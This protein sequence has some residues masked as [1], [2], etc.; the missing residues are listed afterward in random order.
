M[1]KLKLSGLGVLAGAAMLMSGAWYY[2]KQPYWVW[3]IMAALCG[4]VIAMLDG[5]D[6]RFKAKITVPSMG[7]GAAIV[8]TMGSLYYQFIKDYG[9]TGVIP[10]A[11]I[12]AII[13]LLFA[14]I[15]RV[16]KPKS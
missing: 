4:V 11:A 10:M 12:W 15:I 1:T 9:N 2:D 14:G 8:M 5:A 6:I 13:A 3:L 16:I 7:L